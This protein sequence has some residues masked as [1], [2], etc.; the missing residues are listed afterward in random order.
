MKHS[1]LGSQWNRWDL[2]FH[3][4]RSFDYLGGALTNA[5]IVSRLRA[6]NIRLVAITDHHA[7]DVA[8]IRELQ[9]LGGDDLTVLPGIELRSELGGKPVHYILLFSEECDLDHVWS[10]LEGTLGITAQGVADRGGD[11]NFY[12][13]LEKG[14]ELAHKLGGL[15]SMHAGT[16]SNTINEISNSTEYLQQFKCDISRDHVDIYEIGKL[17]DVEVHEQTIFPAIGKKLPLV[18]CSDNHD[19]SKYV[20][21]TSL[22]LKADPTFRGLR[23]V[24]R[25]PQS[26]VYLGEEPPDL[27]RVRKNPTRY[28]RSVEFAPVGE[29]DADHKWFRCRVDFNHGLVAIIGNKG[30][31]KSALS[32]TMGLLGSSRNQA[33]FSFLSKQRFCHPRTGKAS[34]FN[35]IATWESGENI[36]R[37]LDESIEVER[38][39]YLPQE[40][41]ES[42]CNELA[43]EG[44]GAFE[45]EL[46]TVIF[47]HVDEADRLGQQSLDEL[48]DEHTKAKDRR[49]DSLLAGLRQQ[50]RNRA[51]LEKKADPAS[52]RDL[53]NQL[54]E[55]QSALAAHDS[56]KPTEVEKPVAADG[57]AQLTPLQKQI[58][59]AEKK[60]EELAASIGTAEKGL[61]TAKKRHAE[62]TRLLEGLVN[63]EKDVASAVE[64]LRVDANQ[65]GLNIDALI[66]LVVDKKAVEDRLADEAGRIKEL[67]TSL[68]G[69]STAETS[70]L[71]SELQGSKAT[72]SGLQKQLDAPAKKYQKYLTD[73]K[74]WETRR[75]GIVGDE[76]TAGTIVALEKAIADLALLP[77][78]IKKAQQE[79]EATMQSIYSVKMELVEV[80]QKLYGPVEDFVAKQYAGIDAPSLSFR[81]DLACSNFEQQFFD[82]VAQSRKGTFHGAEEGRERVHQ[83]ITA[84]DWSKQDDVKKFVSS[85]DLAL[86]QDQR[87]SPA[88][89]VTV[90]SQMKKGHSPEDLLAYLY[91]LEYLAPRYFL[92]WQEKELSVLSPGERGSVLLI[93]YLLI[94]KSEQPLVIDQ[95]EGNLDNHTVAKHLVQ[96][97]RQAR[98]RRQVFIVTHN[99]NLAVV[100]DADQVVYAS[101]DKGDGNTVSY[102]SGA[103][104]NP[105]MT[106]HATDVLE[107]T[108]E[109]FHIRGSKYLI[110]ELP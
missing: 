1:Q 36:P 79:M 20:T 89:D 19:A 64:N 67:D 2:H 63:V 92:K 53:E 5:D 57:E 110:A 85:V 83:L 102:C 60:S 109:A 56:V 29:V 15:V 94:D 4:P 75:K 50:A 71:R 24:L 3:T 38:V 10:T 81:A 61:V 48:L 22:W 44:G 25:E 104:E 108:K 76:T 47:S 27:Q 84:T 93:F 55:R 37:K 77:E 101:I 42:V 9:T 70:G 54:T 45:R 96:C 88:Q 21:K 12:V 46:K 7:M 105:A 106:T 33:S 68:D 91:S 30:S 103:L 14:A 34:Q 13:P 51:A 41:V 100:C 90:A 66:K 74:E 62:A 80:Y 8:R 16:K 65:L 40:H 49:I 39:K 99:P 17:A 26:R 82:R 58:A 18:I 28:L 31:G 59:D 72:V 23:M 73:L 97:I 98:N 69:D 35:A 78:Q 87:T 107:G 95:P 11:D 86:H 43:G 52:R 6:A 32:D